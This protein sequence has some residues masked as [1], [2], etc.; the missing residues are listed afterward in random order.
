[1]NVSNERKRSAKTGPDRCGLLK[2]SM[3]KI[4]LLVCSS[5]QVK[6]FMQQQ[7]C[8]KTSPFIMWGGLMHVAFGTLVTTQI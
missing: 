5:L 1:M 3:L 2:N 7:D 8:D 4:A 6:P